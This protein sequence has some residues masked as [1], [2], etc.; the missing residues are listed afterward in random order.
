MYKLGYNWL[1][2]GSKVI[3]IIRNDYGSGFNSRLLHQDKKTRSPQPPCRYRHRVFLYLSHAY[4]N[5]KRKGRGVSHPATLILL[6]PITREQLIC[7]HLA[8][9]LRPYGLTTSIGCLLSYYNASFLLSIDYFL[10]SSFLLSCAI[11]FLIAS[12]II[13]TNSSIMPFTSAPAS[14]PRMSLCKSIVPTTFIILAI[15]FSSFPLLSF[16]A[17]FFSFGS[18]ISTLF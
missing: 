17:F 15:F 4:Y 3:D 7:T 16:Y 18:T 6:P 11:S 14:L 1:V 12:L 5:I 8:P 2:W 13:G 9:I 10:I